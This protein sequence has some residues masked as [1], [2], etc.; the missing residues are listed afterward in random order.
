MSLGTSLVYCLKNLSMRKFLFNL[1]FFLVAI[2]AFCQLTV[3]KHFSDHMVLQRDQPVSVSGYTLANA[4]VTLEFGDVHL[5]ATADGNGRWSLLLPAQKAQHNSQSLVIRSSDQQL[6]FEDIVVGDIWLLIGQSNMEFEL[7]AEAHYQMEKNNLDHPLLRFY[8]PSFAGKYIFNRHFKD[9]VLNRLTPELFY[10]AVDWKVSD[11]TSA[12]SISAVGYY[13]AR[14]ILATEKVPIGLIHLAIGGAPIETFISKQ[15]FKEHPEFYLKAKGNWLY[16]DA[17]ADWVRERGRQNV[18][19]RFIYADCNGPNHAYK[20]GFAFKS[21]VQPL[22]GFPIKGV[23]W[24]QGESNAQ[25][26]DRVMEYNA[27][28]KLMVAEYRELWKQP[29]LPFYYAQLSS[30]DTLQYKGQLWPVFRNQQRLFLQQTKNTG[31]AVT[32]DV[33]AKHDVHPRDKKTVGERLSLWALRDVY[34]HDITVSGPLVSKATYRRG[35]LIV[36]FTSVGKGLVCKGKRLLGFYVDG[37]AVQAQ[38][39]GKRVLIKVQ[40][41]PKEVAYGLSSFSRGNLINK[42]GLPASTFI[43]RVE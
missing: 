6:T 22:K 25:E 37:K 36:D 13:F 11:A 1:F 32:S 20:P 18:G 15:A 2:K 35:Q 31:M 40:E 19:K 23:L 16:N 43:V 33:G 10:T 24:Y 21:G 42:E 8:N 34:H 4:Q 29:E 7:Q 41:K 26:M 14:R 17:L 27:L 9:S 30:I 38:I 39:K 3:E 28:Q 5:Q 12:P